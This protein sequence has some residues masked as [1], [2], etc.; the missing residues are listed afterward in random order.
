MVGIKDL[1]KQMVGYLGG[2][3]AGSNPFEVSKMKVTNTV[4]LTIIHAEAEGFTDRCQ[5]RATKPAH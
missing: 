1:K 3:R 5:A 2:V 4:L